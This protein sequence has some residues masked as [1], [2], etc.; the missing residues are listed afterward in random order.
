MS[1][2]SPIRCAGCRQLLGHTHA[3]APPRI[4]CT[5]PICRY[6]PSVRLNESRDDY[7]LLMHKLGASVNDLGE[8]FL[9]SN[10]R[11]HQILDERASTH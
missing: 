10:S 6:L 4:W 7:I 1:A 5:N 11:I 2:G 3:A 9:L 8:S